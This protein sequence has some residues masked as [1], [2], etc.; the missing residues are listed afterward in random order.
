MEEGEWWIGRKR[1]EGRERGSHSISPLPPPSSSA[2]SFIR[3]HLLKEGV[4]GREG[5][6]TGG[7]EGGSRLKN[8]QRRLPCELRKVTQDYGI[9]QGPLPYSR[10]IKG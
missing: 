3:Q 2:S 1:R 7:R 6:R 8:T 5:G 4:G 9:R 10:G